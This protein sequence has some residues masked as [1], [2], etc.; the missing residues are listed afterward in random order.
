ML[1]VQKAQDYYGFAGGWRP[2]RVGGEPEEAAAGPGRDEAAQLQAA[3]DPQLARRASLEHLEELLE[4][5]S[6]LGGEEAP[7]LA[8][9]EGE[10]VLLRK[11]A[12][13]WQEEPFQAEV[14]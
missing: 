2:Q 7:W 5:P 12:G 10:I 6:H 14:E 9:A 3:G 13:L 1:D 11:E 4:E 8:A